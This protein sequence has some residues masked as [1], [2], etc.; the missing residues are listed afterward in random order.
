MRFSNFETGK[1]NEDIKDIY[2]ITLI[3]N[4][5]VKIIPPC[6][7]LLL[8]A[9]Y[10]EG[11]VVVAGVTVQASPAVPPSRYLGVWSRRGYY[12]KRVRTTERE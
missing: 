4:L 3:K 5:N 6:L 9:V 2:C 7:M 12:M 11:V 1:S 10:R 8:Q